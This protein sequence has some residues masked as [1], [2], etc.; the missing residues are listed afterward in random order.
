MRRGIFNVTSMAEP[1]MGVLLGAL[2][3]PNYQPP[4]QLGNSSF[5]ALC[6]SQLSQSF[7]TQ[8]PM[9]L[10]QKLPTGLKHTV[11]AFNPCSQALWSEPSPREN[12]LPFGWAA[13][14]WSCIWFSSFHF[15]SLGLPLIGRLPIASHLQHWLHLR[16]MWG[17][18]G[19]V[20]SWRAF[21]KY[22][23]CCIT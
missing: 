22:E 13:S 11:T 5:S 23:H 18:G 16:I 19:G 21:K 8:L 3:S 17:G 1:I 12:E 20:E 2:N 9:L 6:W 14:S 7:K 10:L 4:F 15:H